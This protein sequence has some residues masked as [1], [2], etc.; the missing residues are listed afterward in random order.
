MSIPAA[1]YA[2][3]ADARNLRYWDGVA[4]TNH[5]APAPVATP[6]PQLQPQLEP[7]A[8][9]P[10]PAAQFAETA[11]SIGYQPTSQFSAS[12]YDASSYGMT[13][14]GSST[15]SGGS[16]GYNSWAP[17]TATPSYATQ[18]SA[19]SALANAAG[20]G[21]NIWGIIFGIFCIVGAIVAIQIIES[22]NAAAPGS[23]S[24]NG[25]V[26]KLDLDGE[27]CSPEVDITVDGEQ[28]IVSS[29]LAVKPCP[30][31]LGQ[32]VPVSYVP[33]QVEST[34]TVTDS[35]STTPITI[36]KYTSIAIGIAL[37]LRNGY[38]LYRRKTGI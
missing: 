1:W 26:S 21:G 18:P 29:G 33:G 38:S 12:N 4:W 32:T 13:G 24:V 6:Q 19:R 17:Q 37:I 22:A 36:G 31:R 27:Y 9:A 14:L 20:I 23:V 15:A 3:P 7:A 34:A 16:N 30:W 35:T 28:W 10:A 5:V 25:T 8:Y 11:S 2:D